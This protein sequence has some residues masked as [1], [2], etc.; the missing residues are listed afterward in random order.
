MLLK[1]VTAGILL[2]TCTGCMTVRSVTSPR[3]FL[4]TNQPGR[5]WVTTSQT[6]ASTEIDSPRV[7]TD[8]VFGFDIKGEQVVYPIAEIKEL[9][10]KQLNVAKSA[11]MVGL[12]T[13]AGVAA[14]AAFQ[15]LKGDAPTVEETEDFR[16]RSFV[17]LFQ[18]KIP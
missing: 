5:I 14:I 7:L 17:P 9:R 16:A 4:N 2:I 15:G 13:A 12:F 11:V 1:R 8:T 6:A 3:D 10:A 18:I